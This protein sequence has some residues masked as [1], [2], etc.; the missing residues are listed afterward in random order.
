MDGGAA[1]DGFKYLEMFPSVY[2][3]GSDKWH[4]IIKKYVA[5]EK[6]LCLR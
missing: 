1:G 4:L 2:L 3:R 6:Y 5:E